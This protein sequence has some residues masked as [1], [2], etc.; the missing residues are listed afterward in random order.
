[1]TLQRPLALAAGVIVLVFVSGC[2]RGSE[3]L[4]TPT[5]ARSAFNRQRLQTDVIFDCFSTEG[6]PMMCPVS[7]AHG[8]PHVFGLVAS[9]IPVSKTDLEDVLQAWVLDSGSAAR[10][11]NRLRPA[12]D[13]TGKTIP[14]S[15][16]RLQRGNIVVW[17]TRHGDYRHRA[18]VALAALR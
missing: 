6:R 5:Q 14:P 11:F 17:V 9:R 10:S 18:V 3:N 7:A 2:G 16:L 4:M 1:M 12:L 13:S 15:V 8:A